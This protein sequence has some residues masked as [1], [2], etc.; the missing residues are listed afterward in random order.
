MILTILMTRTL[1]R[2]CKPGE[3]RR[4]AA[5]EIVQSDIDPMSSFDIRSVH[6]VVI[7]FVDVLDH[8]R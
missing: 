4:F 5:L 8:N 3:R 2:M 6:Y 1:T 7:A